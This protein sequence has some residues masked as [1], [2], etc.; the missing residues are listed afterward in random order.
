MYLSLL[1][2]C[3]LLVPDMMESV[4]VDSGAIKF[5]LSGADIMCP[6]LT[7]A[8]GRI[9]PELKEG[10]VVAVMAEGKEHALGIGILKMSGANMYNG[11]FMVF[12]FIVSRV[13]KD[14]AL[15]VF[16]F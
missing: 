8:G 2:V 3:D 13:T 4:Q 12:D 14:T 5:I 16:I 7:S 6:G 15:K 10:A 1:V 9:R 11:S